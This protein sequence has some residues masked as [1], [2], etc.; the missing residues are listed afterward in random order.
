[1]VTKAKT[2]SS[3]VMWVWGDESKGIAVVR[4]LRKQGGKYWYDVHH[5]K[6]SKVTHVARDFSSKAEAL[7]Q[8][9]SYARLAK[10]HPRS[11]TFF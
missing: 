11:A 1:M 7:R 5:V 4:S 6:N 9:Q 8:A 10:K 2:A 3:R